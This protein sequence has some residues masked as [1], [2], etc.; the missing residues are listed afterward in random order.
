[1]IHF[2]LFQAPRKYPR[3]HIPQNRSR[4]I[5]ADPAKLRLPAGRH[6]AVGDAVPAKTRILDLHQVSMPAAR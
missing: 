2:T 6:C 5:P 1:M 4:A 3:A